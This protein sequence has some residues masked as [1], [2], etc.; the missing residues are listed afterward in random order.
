MRKL[1]PLFL[2][3]AACGG[4]SGTASADSAGT[5]VASR[6]IAD[7]PSAV[8][9]AERGVVLGVRIGMTIDSLKAALGTPVREGVDLGDSVPTTVLEFPMGTVKLRG[10]AGVVHFLC[11]GDDC[12]TMDGVGIGDTLD[13]ILGTY[14]PTPPRGPL[15]SPEA[16]DYRLGTTDCNLTFTLASGRVTSLALGCAVH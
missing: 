3:L 16:L 5:G 8:I 12:R 10:G 15:E 14:G 11:G 4:G 1:S 2:L 9:E 7:E 13:V 6:T